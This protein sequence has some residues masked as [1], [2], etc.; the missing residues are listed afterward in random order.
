M[1]RSLRATKNWASTPD[2]PPKPQPKMSNKEFRSIC[3]Q[4]GLRDNATASEL[5]GPNWRTCQ[6]YWYDEV[7]V[8]NPLA[9]LLRLAV[10]LKLS[11]LDLR[12]AAVPLVLQDTRQIAGTDL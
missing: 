5:L 11:H 10:R 9:R 12:K 1:R 2:K 8:P 6:R 7:A 3:A 4:L